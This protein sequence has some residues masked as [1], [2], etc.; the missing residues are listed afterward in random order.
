[1]VLID[2]KVN[3]EHRP[4]AQQYT[5]LWVWAPTCGFLLAD[6]CPEQAVGTFGLCLIHTILKRLIKPYLTTLIF[7]TCWINWEGGPI[8]MDHMC[9]LL[10][11][12]A[13]F[14]QLPVVIL[15]C[16]LFISHILTTQYRVEMKRYP[17]QM[18]SDP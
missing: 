17:C 15:W 6:N 9:H 3:A 18:L 7:F 13:L 12:C 14:G 2:M 4:T 8:C 10:S 5:Y 16:G 11:R 1:M